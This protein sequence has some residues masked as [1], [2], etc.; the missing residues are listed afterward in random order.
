MKSQQRAELIWGAIAMA[1]ERIEWDWW[2][3]WFFDYLCADDHWDA[4][5]L[6]KEA[7]LEAHPDLRDRYES[8]E[9]DLFWMM[10]NLYGTLIP[11]K[12]SLAFEVYCWMGFIPS[13]IRSLQK[14]FRSF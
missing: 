7:V 9:I 13:C 12:E 5:D 4:L 6:W 3:T 11:I 10:D 1:T 14:L 2:G 8:G